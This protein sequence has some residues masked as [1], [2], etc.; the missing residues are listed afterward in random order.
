MPS[1]DWNREIIRRNATQNPNY[2][3]YC[4]RC[5]GL[6]RMKKVEHMYWRCDYCLAEHDE[7]TP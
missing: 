7:R 4:G 5:H 6:V 1:E 3:P 2:A